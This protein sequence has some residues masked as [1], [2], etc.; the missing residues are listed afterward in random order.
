MQNQET[1]TQTEKAIE[2]AI[3]QV[4]LRVDNFNRQSEALWRKKLKEMG[5]SIE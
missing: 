4:M 3:D 1:Q 2:E 5:L